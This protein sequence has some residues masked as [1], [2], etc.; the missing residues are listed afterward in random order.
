MTN[1]CA[2]SDSDKGR[3]TVFYAMPIGISALCKL[4]MKNKACIFHVSVFDAGRVTKSSHLYTTLQREA[5]SSSTPVRLV[6]ASTFR[7][8]RVYRVAHPQGLAL[9]NKH[10][11]WILNHKI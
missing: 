1:M 9:G 11:E 6:D 7:R 4:L 10:G 3:C 2:F 8:H 5:Y